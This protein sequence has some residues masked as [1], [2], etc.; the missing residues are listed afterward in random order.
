LRIR[1]R[2]KIIKKY[3]KSKEGTRTRTRMGTGIDKK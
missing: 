1:I 2:I 3:I